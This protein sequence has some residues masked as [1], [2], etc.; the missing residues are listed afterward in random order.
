MNQ[1][2]QN[3]ID[4]SIALIQRAEKLALKMS[5]LDGFYLA[6]SGGKDS[7]VCHELMNMAGVQFKSVY[8]VTTNDPAENIIF[9]KQHYTDVIF[10]IPKKSFIQLVK[11]KGLPTITRRWC[12]QYFK[13]TKGT[14]HVVVAGIRKE[15]S[16]KRAQY[17][18]VTIAG[19]TKKDYRPMNIIEMENNQF[20]CVN[21]NDKIMLYPILDWTINN[22]WDFIKMRNL[23]INPCYKIF[24]RVG[25]AFCPFQPRK[26][27]L[28]YC[29]SH[30][31]QT[32]ALINAINIYIERGKHTAKISDANDY[33]DSWTRKESYQ[34]YLAQK[35]QLELPLLD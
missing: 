18:E 9:I 4:S 33:F 6:F 24:S 25:C 11:T 5:P 19:K 3:K 30:P 23:P 28:T 14:N 31:K 2:L 17:K 8:N 12:C 34:E 13:E 15:E 16:K 26:L 29:Q 21:G 20:Q 7:Q 32:Q 27:T 22:V 1:E 35:N 10:D